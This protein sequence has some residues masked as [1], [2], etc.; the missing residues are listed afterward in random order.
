[1]SIEIYKK[2]TIVVL[3]T[4]HYKYHN[5]LC[6]KKYACEANYG[7]TNFFSAHQQQCLAN[8]TAQTQILSSKE[9]AVYSHQNVA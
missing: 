3:A 4:T 6:I 8:M 1:M 2:S 5:I 7:Q 9:R